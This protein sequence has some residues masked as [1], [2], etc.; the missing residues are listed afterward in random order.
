MSS[1]SPGEEA[2]WKALAKASPFDVCQR[3]L[4]R[5]EESS[6]RYV[7]KVLGDD[8]AIATRRQRIESIPNIARPLN[9]DFRL[10][11]LTYLTN[12]KEIELSG[13]LVQCSQLRGGDSFFK[14]VHALPVR[15]SEDRFGE[16]P[17]LFR[18]AC[19]SLDGREVPYGDT[20]VEIKVLPRLPL[21]FVLWAADDEFPAR[22]SILFDST[23]D[24]HLPLDALLAAV[25]TTIKRII[26]RSQGG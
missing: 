5:F 17:Q 3:T 2:A 7:L 14:G 24:E 12:A 6:E 19:L 20:A 23:A 8:Y 11:I 10:M 22:V 1:I 4:A 16:S 18:D 26:D 25:R 15:E 13:Q 9:L 21:T